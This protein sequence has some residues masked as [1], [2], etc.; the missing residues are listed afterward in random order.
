MNDSPWLAAMQRGCYRSTVPAVARNNSQFFA[1]NALYSRQSLWMTIAKVIEYRHLEPGVQ[2][3]EA[4]MR[5]YITCT[6]RDKNHDG[7]IL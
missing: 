5:P 4:G 2:Q 3:L 1:G 7:L 6:A